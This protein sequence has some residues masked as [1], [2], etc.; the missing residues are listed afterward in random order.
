[1]T[2]IRP[3]TTEDRPMLESWIAAEPDHANN[4]FEFYEQPKTKSVVYEDEL[5]P[6]FVARFS[7]AL[8]IDMEFSNSA[9]KERIRKVLKEGFPEV[10]KQAR[11][12]G[13]SE[14]VFSS[15]SKTL[16][17]FCRAFGFRS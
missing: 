4:T 17:A 6:V 8:R 11:D 16:I 10:A 12:Q 14:I 3:V 1:M 7:S 2:I 15:I 5:G 9:S 13:F